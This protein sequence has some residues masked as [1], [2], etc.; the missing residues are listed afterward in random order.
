M[1]TPVQ[2][3][4]S[5]NEINTAAFE[6]FR[7]T[8][9]PWMDMIKG[10]LAKSGDANGNGTSWRAADVSKLWSTWNNGFANNG[11]NI[12]NETARKIITVG[13]EQQKLCTD[14]TASWLTSVT[15]MMEVIGDG[16]QNNE[17]PANVTKACKDLAAD[18]RRSCTAFIE[19]EWALICDAFLSRGSGLEKSEKPEKTKSAGQTEKAS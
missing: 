2:I 16:L 17:A 19:S 7:A 13:L 11:K 12:Q 14:L 5:I 18:Y 10:S 15:K 8:A 4:P 3:A 1:E 6:L 9:E